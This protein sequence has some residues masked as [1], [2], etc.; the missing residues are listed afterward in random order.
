MFFSLYNRAQLYNNFVFEHIYVNID[1]KIY[2]IF[3]IFRLKN[4]NY[5]SKKYFN[6][7]SSTVLRTN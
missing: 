2:N 7:L 6:T 5:I 4:N 1:D 3:N